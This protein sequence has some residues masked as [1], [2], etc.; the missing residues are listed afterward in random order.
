MEFNQN[1]P[2]THF[3]CVAVSLPQHSYNIKYSIPA[4]S[5]KHIASTLP[6]LSI[7]TLPYAVP[8]IYSLKLIHIF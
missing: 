1:K 7:P 5:H 8:P 6:I 3:V 2:S 4:T